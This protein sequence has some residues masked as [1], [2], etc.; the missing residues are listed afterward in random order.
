M[1][2]KTKFIPSMKQNVD[3]AALALIVE[4]QHQ[5]QVKQLF[6]VLA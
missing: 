5:F 3:T 4:P 6:T 2:M 1:K